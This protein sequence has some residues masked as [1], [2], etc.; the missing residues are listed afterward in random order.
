[1]L[2]AS[3]PPAGTVAL[4]GRGGTLVAG[5]AAVPCGVDVVPA[6]ARRLAKAATRSLEPVGLAD[7]VAAGEAWGVLYSPGRCAG[8]RRTWSGVNVHRFRGC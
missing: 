8:V 5:L 4:E 6:K 2:Q 3:G 1:M 7:L